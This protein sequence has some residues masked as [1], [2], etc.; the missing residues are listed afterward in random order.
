MACNSL[1]VLVQAHIIDTIVFW[2]HHFSYC[3]EFP[4]FF[5]LS[6]HVAFLTLAHVFSEGE[7]VGSS[8]DK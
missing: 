2:R 5:G 3:M 4:A 1:L 7:G 8:V 6:V